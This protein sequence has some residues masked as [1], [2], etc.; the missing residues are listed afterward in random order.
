MESACASADGLAPSRLS[1][2]FLFV[3]WMLKE[4]LDEVDA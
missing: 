2:C 3:A 1:A 4:R